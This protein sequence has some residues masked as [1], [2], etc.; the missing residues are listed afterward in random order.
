MWILPIGL[1]LLATEIPGLSAESDDKQEAAIA[2][3]RKLGGKFRSLGGGVVF[4]NLKRFWC[5]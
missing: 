2:E 5:I 1:L 3:I 4:L